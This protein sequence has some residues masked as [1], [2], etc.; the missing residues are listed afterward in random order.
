[1]FFVF[2][3]NLFSVVTNSNTL[4]FFEFLVSLCRMSVYQITGL[5]VWA[6]P[7]CGMQMKKAL[8][9]DDCAA[10]TNEMLAAVSLR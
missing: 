3:Q 8:G 5:R 7:G 4:V 1:M 2:K 10:A 9:A 6:A